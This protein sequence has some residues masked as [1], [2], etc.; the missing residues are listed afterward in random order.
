MDLVFYAR[1]IRK[2]WSLILLG[3]L[4]ATAAASYSTLQATPLYETTI[5][6]Y[7][8]GQAAADVEGAL[9]SGF[10]SEQRVRSYA[11]L[12]DSTPVRTR[13]LKTIGSNSPGGVAV[14]PIAETALITVRITHPD[15]RQAQR[16]AN[17]YGQVIPQI[18]DEI[19]RPVRGGPSLIKATVVEPAELPRR[20][21]SPKKGR[22]LALGALL[23]LVIGG[24]AALLAEALDTSVKSAAD[25][26]EATDM[27]VLGALA[28]DPGVPRQPLTVHSQ[29]R[30]RKSE[31]FRQLR[32]NI[33]FAEIDN[34]RKSLVVTSATLDE[35][36]SFVS[37]N[38][39]IA[40]AQAGERVILVEADLR[41]PSVREYMGFEGTVG[42][43]DVLINRSKLADVLQDWGGGLLRVLPGGRIPPNP[44]ELLGSMSMHDVVD[45]LERMADVVVLDSPPLLPVTDAAVLSVHAGGVLMVVRAGRTSREQVR[46]AVESLHA[47]NARVV[48]GVLNM[49]PTKGPDAYTY[50]YDGYYHPEESDMPATS[51]PSPARRGRAAANGISRTATGDAAERISAAAV[52]GLRQGSRWRRVD[53]APPP[54]APPAPPFPA[55]TPAPEGSETTGTHGAGVP[56]A[57]PPGSGPMP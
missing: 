52:A 30:S 20:P 2:R 14:R 12:L 46:R 49:T 3:V 8:T 10:L 29:P 5:K 50:T 33:Q 38:L 51:R 44:S 19:E 35:G 1:L 54:S 16:L 32:T 27:T 26:R 45:Q 6:L 34:A 18:I 36:K 41:R 37:C 57:R 25:L 7:I 13:V 39:A 11:N 9:Q 28:Y 21:G 31:A 17:G 55:A 24:S 56:P 47:V 43:T 22:N 48:G 4:V 23:G 15:P 53:V 40:M 42:L